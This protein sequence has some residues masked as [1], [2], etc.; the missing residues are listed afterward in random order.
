M[1]LNSVVLPEPLG[2]MTAFTLPR[3]NRTVA[4]PS[5]ATP[6]N[7]FVSPAV[8]RLS[9]PSGSLDRDRLTDQPPSR[10]RPAGLARRAR[11]ARRAGLARRVRAERRPAARR[12]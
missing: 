12:R 11:G 4:P 7:D 6:P 10:R 1:Q 8:S 5:A 3:W 2:P 9:T